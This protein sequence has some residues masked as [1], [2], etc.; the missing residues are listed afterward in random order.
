MFPGYSDSV[1]FSVTCPSEV[2][3]KT[4]ALTEQSARERSVKGYELS[5]TADAGMSGNAQWCDRIWQPPRENVMHWTA[6][7][8]TA[9]SFD[10][11]QAKAMHRSPLVTDA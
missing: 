9:I 4:D 10:L 2:P 5:A 1:D 6:G 11:I 3:F 7:G 8:F